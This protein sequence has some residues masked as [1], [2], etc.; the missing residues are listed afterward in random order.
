MLKKS[1]IGFIPGQLNTNKPYHAASLRA[2]RSNPD[3]TIN[4]VKTQFKLITGLLRPALCRARNDD[5]GGILYL[6]SIA[7]GFILSLV[8]SGCVAPLA[9][10][11]IGAIG[12]S[13]AE[14]R[15]FSGVASDQVLRVKL[16]YELSDFAGFELTIYKGRV[17]L[18]GVVANEQAKINIVNITRN[19]SGVKEIIDCMNVTGEDGFSEYTRDSWM[20]TKLKATLYTDEDIFAP[21]YLVK[22]FDKTIYIFGTAHTKEE[23]DKVMAHAFMITGVRK[24]VNLMEIRTA[25]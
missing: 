7:L 12:M 19:V 22:T 17:L 24:V 6:N 21:N 8:L 14:D 15:G 13:G 10:G 18:T 20:T 16:N 25:G 9:V 2:E 3:K 23:M 11:G 4:C 5:V 1:I